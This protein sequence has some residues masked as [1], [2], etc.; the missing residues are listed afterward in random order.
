LTTVVREIDL[1]ELPCELSDLSA[2]DSA[3]VL[4]RL[5]GRPVGQAWLPV[6]NGRI[7]GTTLR[8]AL[9]RAGG[10]P[11]WQAWAEAYLAPIFPPEGPLPSATIAICTRNRAADLV[12]C[13]RSLQDLPDDGQELI[14]VDNAPAD[15][16]T[17]RVVAQFP[18]VRYIR[19]DRA[20]LAVARNRALHE[21]RGAIVAF[22]DDDA[23]V[24]PGWLRAL[25]RNFSDPLVLGVSGL[26]MPVELTTPAQEWFER[27]APFGRGFERRVFDMTN[28]D[29]L[30]PNSVGS[31]AS[32]AFRRTVLHLVGPF[33]EAFG[34]GTPSKSGAD[35]EYIGRILQLGYRMVYEPAALN[36][37]RHRRD[38][39]DLVRRMHDYGTGRGARWTRNLLLQHEVGVIGN[40]AR[41]LVRYNLPRYI[42]ALLRGRN[43]PLAQLISA[44]LRGW[45]RGPA[46]YL[47]ARRKMRDS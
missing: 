5:Q 31:G 7:D 19:E 13:L 21:A 25:L 38:W 33:D 2:Y 46:A 20:G 6:H 15:D 22:T 24:E 9:F 47:A 34:P 1:L 35:T 16:Q 40:A 36:W 17:R 29:P 37:H 3:F 44:D 28:H 27:F 39:D 4:I 42:A 26:T 11:P 18:G 14:V 30:Q 10:W 32:L 23:T 8:E 45:W 43:A 12:H 41:W